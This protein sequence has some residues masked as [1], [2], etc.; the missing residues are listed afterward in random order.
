MKKFTYFFLAIAIL[1]PAF[2]FAQ[3]SQGNAYRIKGYRDGNMSLLPVSDRYYIASFDSLKICTS[4]DSLGWFVKSYKYEYQ[5]KTNGFW[6]EVRLKSDVIH[7]GISKVIKNSKPNYIR[8]TEIEVGDKQRTIMK[9]KV[10][11]GIL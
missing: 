9:S 8:I 5:D 1:A 6:N 11:I 3:Q 2:V 4:S 10:S 7:S